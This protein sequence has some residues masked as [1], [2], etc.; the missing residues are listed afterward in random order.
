MAA[1]WTPENRFRIW[2]EIEAHACDAMAG[3]PGERK[4]TIISRCVGDAEVE[5]S[6]WD[7]GPGLATAS[8][9]Q[10]F[11]PFRQVEQTMTRTKGGTGL[12]LSVSRKLARLMDG[13]LEIGRTDGN[14]TTF[15]FWLNSRP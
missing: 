3:L 10:V 6:V 5:F 1:I 2:F 7:I 15:I 12:G 4:L 11:E 13:D 8:L 14:G 9:E